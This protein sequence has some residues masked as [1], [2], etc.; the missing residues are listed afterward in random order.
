M[1]SDLPAILFGV[2][3]GIILMYAAVKAGYF[4]P[5]VKFSETIT[6]LEEDVKE[7]KSKL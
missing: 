5:T 6:R 4:A 7:L 2:V 1:F 3:V